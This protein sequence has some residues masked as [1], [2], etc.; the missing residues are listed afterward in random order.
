MIQYSSQQV[1]ID[2]KEI[3]FLEF[4]LILL[5]V[6]A[7][8]LKFRLIFQMRINQ[9]EF[10]YLSYI[11]SYS[12]GSLSEILQTFHVHFFKWFSYFSNNE[13]MQIILARS[14]MFLFFLGTCI[15]T[16]L[17]GRQFINRCGALFAV[18]CF[19]SFS[20]VVVNGSGFRHDTISV[21]LCL[22]S[23]YFIISNPQ[24]KFSSIIAGISMAFSIMF[25]IKSVFH[26]VIIGI[27]ILCMLAM[28]QKRSEV[29]KQIVHFVITFVV[30]YLIFYQLHVS[31]LNIVSSPAQ[32]KFLK[33]V[34]SKFIL[35]DELFPAR[36]FLKLSI[37]QN[38]IIWTLLIAGVF[39]VIWEIVYTKKDKLKKNFILL[40][41]IIPILSLIFYRNAFPYFYVFILTPAIIFSGILFHE[42]T[43]GL[44]KTKS[45]FS[46]ILIIFFTLLVFFNFLFYYFLFSPKRNFSQKELLEKVHKIFPEP[47][48]YIDGCS[49]VASYPK[50]GFF[51]S[52]MGMENYLTM[53]RPIMEDLLNKDKPLFL[54]SNVPQLDLSLPREKAVSYANYSLLEEDWMVL[55]SN[56]LHHWGP[57]YVVGKQFNLSSVANSQNF[58]IFISGNYTLEGEQNV[59]VDGIFYKPG[60]IIKLKKGKHSIAGLYKSGKV[61]L[62]WGKNLYKPSSPPPLDPIFGIFL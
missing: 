47:V 19:L 22:F 23:I 5:I 49:M 2:S 20:Y 3:K 13:V 12:R 7:L 29:I 39:F 60:D 8:C 10:H 52:S 17:I 57:I 37:N 4:G 30:G 33:N 9:D 34:Y 41:F 14:V 59:S 25:T 44:K 1:N 11:Y 50:S 28:T 43:E 18:I 38:L 24:L 31:K 27:I 45:K 58:K 26:L 35:I 42:I 55:K 6:I 51:M 16:Y 32:K 53:N 15:L 61:K 40:A 62:R 54:L 36:T 21:F 48:S 46:L 56:F